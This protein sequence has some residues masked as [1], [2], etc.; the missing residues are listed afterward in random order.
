MFSAF[1]YCFRKNPF[2]L[3]DH[4][5]L[6]FLLNILKNCLSQDVF[7]LC[8]CMAVCV[9]S[10]HDSPSLRILPALFKE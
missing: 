9:D 2:L 10:H 7:D 1:V 3:R 4:I 5:L 6:Y 8:V